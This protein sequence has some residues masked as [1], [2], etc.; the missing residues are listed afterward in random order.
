MAQE[1]LKVEHLSAAYGGI[2]ALDDVSME[3]KEGEIVAVLGAN[4]AGKSTLLK[5]LSSERKPS[6]GTI[7]FGGKPLPS[8]PYDVVESGMVIVPEGRQIFYKLTVY[9]NLQIGCSLRRDRDGIKNDLEMV[10]QMFP[11]LKEREKQYG[12]LLSGG[13]QQMLAIARGLMARPKLMMLDEPSL[14]LAPIIVKQ[15]MD[16]LRQVNAGGT[17]ILLIEQNAHKA[18]QLCDRA[19]LMNV[20]HVVAEGTGE[21]L[22]ADEQLMQAYLG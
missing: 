15:I 6:G 14:G 7:T 2:R 5:C 10:Y 21:A 18:L 1:L 11:R 20:G 19:Y 4:G 17:T 12:G 16:I 22:L 9:E 13:E 8:K 3:I